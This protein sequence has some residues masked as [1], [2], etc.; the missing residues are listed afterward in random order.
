MIIHS[1]LLLSLTFCVGTKPIGD[2]RIEEN[3]SEPAIN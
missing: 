2:V 3:L 1:S